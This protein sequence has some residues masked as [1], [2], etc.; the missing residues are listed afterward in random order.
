MVNCSGD[1]VQVI[2]FGVEGKGHFLADFAQV[3][4]G[5][6]PIGV[7]DKGCSDFLADGFGVGDASF[8]QGGI[9]EIS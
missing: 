3:F 9:N 1:F 8:E 6:C 2:F 4:I 5:G 7:F